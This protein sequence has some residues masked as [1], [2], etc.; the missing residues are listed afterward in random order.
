[1]GAGCAGG[2][3]SGFTFEHLCDAGADGVLERD[4]IDE[5]AGGVLHSAHDLGG[6]EGGGERGVGAGGVD[7]GNDGE[8]FEEIPLGQRCGGCLGHQ[9]AEDWERG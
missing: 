9:V 7:E 5:A 4:E 8:F 6:H 2:D 3:D 1:M